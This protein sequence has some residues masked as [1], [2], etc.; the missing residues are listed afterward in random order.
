MTFSSYQLSALLIITCCSCK[1]VPTL[2]HKLSEYANSNCT[3]FAYSAASE[4]FITNDAGRRLPGVTIT[5]ISLVLTADELRE[6]TNSAFG[7]TCDPVL[8]GIIRGEYWRLQQAKS[9]NLSLPNYLSYW[10]KYSLLSVE[11]NKRITAT[12][13]R[14]AAVFRISV[15]TNDFGKPFT[16]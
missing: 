1:K 11:A 9:T 6:R 4:F 2:G 12:H 13:P 14:R 10:G 16:E 15:D 5:R 8:S 7:I 3:L